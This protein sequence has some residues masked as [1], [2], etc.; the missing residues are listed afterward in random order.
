MALSLRA[1]VTLAWSMFRDPGVPL[2]P[3]AILP[4]IVGYLA[5]PFDIIPDFIPILGQLDDLLVIVAGLGI[6]LWMTPRDVIEFHLRAL[7]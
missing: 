2:L 1:K 4:V 5:F 7:E 3:K 6:F